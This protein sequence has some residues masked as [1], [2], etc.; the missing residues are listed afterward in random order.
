MA[1]ILCN[2]QFS[3]LF[4]YKQWDSAPVKRRGDDYDG[5]KN[6]IGEAL[7]EQTCTIF[8][9]L[10]DHID[11]KDIGSPVTNK[12][13]IAQP[14]GEIYGL[15]HSKERMSPWMSAQ[16]R[17]KTDIPGLYLTGQ[18]VL[19]CG[20][21]GALF[22]GLLAAGVILERNVMNDLIGLHKSTKPMKKNE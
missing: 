12:H 19:S 14:H 13:Y 9:Q 11:Y 5:V 20:F 18:D 22:G 7:I 21:T 2:S 1:A 4:R 3:F 6:T 17:P 16:L 15:D 8:P 10:R